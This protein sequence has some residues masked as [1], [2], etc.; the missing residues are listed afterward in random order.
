MGPIDAFVWTFPTD[1]RTF[2]FQ[3]DAGWAEWLGWDDLSTHTWT[4]FP[5]TAYAY[6]PETAQHLVG[7]SAGRVLALSLDATTDATATPSRR[8][9]AYVQTGFINHDTDARK[10]CVCVR[11]ALR[12]GET[13]SSTGP[14]GFFWWA[15]RPGETMD[16]I[17]ID[18]GASGDFEIVLEFWGLGVYRRRQ[19]F[20][21]FA[22]TERL[23]LVGAT[24][25]YNVLE[26]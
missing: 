14:Q 3:R 24:E 5:I 26:E 20:F 11:I 2:V 16:H 23:V 15:D 12:R 21:E 8:I 1:G 6:R 22:G 9:R 10:E 18:L 13:Q 25:V 17:P 7:D 19:W 4:Q